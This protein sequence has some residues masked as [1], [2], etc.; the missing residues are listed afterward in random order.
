MRLREYSF[1]TQWRV[2]GSLPRVYSVLNDVSRYPQW[3]PQLAQE[4]RCLSRPGSTPGHERGAITTK[5]FL[6]YVLRWTYEVTHSEPPHTFSIKAE[7]DIEGDGRWVLEQNGSNV[8][9]TYYW[10]VR[11][12]KTLLKF[13]SP[14]FRPV[15][16][17]N[18]DWV[19]ARGKEGLRR[20]LR[21]IAIH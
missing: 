2:A 7:G 13:L 9:I 12:E 19:M 21:Y 10:N 14:L 16:A 17:L 5:G 4:F 20:E 1:V 3:W 15:F 11:T 18:H 6:P 8:D